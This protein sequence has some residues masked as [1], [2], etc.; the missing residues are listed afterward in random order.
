M[1]FLPWTKVAVVVA[2]VWQRSLP[3]WHQSTAG[4]ICKCQAGA[5]HVR[6]ACLTSAVE[7]RSGE[8][9]LCFHWS[10][11]RAR[12]MARI[13]TSSIYCFGWR[14]YMAPEV[15]NMMEKPGFIQWL[16]LSG[17]CCLASILLN[18][19][20]AFFVQRWLGISLVVPLFDVGILTAFCWLSFGRRNFVNKKADMLFW[21][22]HYGLVPAETVMLIKE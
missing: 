4:S 11:Q 13:I 6:Q 18:L 19:I 7:L 17:R 5:I 21:S 22:V 15:I 10:F 20:L 9:V 14:Q 3:Y 12:M 1:I 2:T 8:S 16:L